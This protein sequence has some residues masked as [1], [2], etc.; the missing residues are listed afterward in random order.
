MKII[1][2]VTN[3]KDWDFDIKDIEVVTGKQYLTNPDYSK[4]KNARVFNLCRDYKYQNTGYY[5]SLLAAARKHKAIPSIETIQEMKS[6]S[7]VKILSTELDSLI[8]KSLKEI[9][10]RK[11]TLSIYFGKNLSKKYDALSMQLFNLFQSP[12]IR[13]H[14]SFNNNKW[15]IQNI[16]PIASGDIPEEHHPFVEEAAKK[17]FEAKKFTVPERTS[18]AYSMAILWDPLEKTAPSSEKTLQKFIKASNQKGIQ[19]N[20]ITKDDYSTLSSYDALFI[21][22]TT[23]VNHH[24]FR[25]AQRAKAEGLVV[26][27]DPESIIKCSNKVYLAEL[28]KMHN[29]EAPETLIIH[30]ENISIAP[31]ILGFPI[32]LKQPDSAFS[33]G[34]SKAENLEEY[35]KK[36]SLLLEKSDLIIG[37]QFLQTDFDWRVGV[38]NGEAIYACKYYMSKE[39]WQIVN[40]NKNGQYGKVETLPVELAPPA[41]IKTAEK[42]SRLIGNSLYGVDIK[43]KGNKFFVIEINDNPNIDT[44][45]EDAILKDKLYSKMVDIFLERIQKSKQIA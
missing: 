29:I 10:S 1:I 33:Q 38:F 31:D 2:T 35:K 6:A 21:R 43:Q 20:L 22:E 16:S 13:A 25:F 32:I 45:V 39:H 11:Y 44:G 4:L 18:S 7:V 37:Q 36:V 12:F 15:S 8:Q 27:D 14:F 17:Y 5:V 23:A 3:L 41:L 19:A 34:V 28:L 30:K 26:V 40:W 9:K 42:L 24:T